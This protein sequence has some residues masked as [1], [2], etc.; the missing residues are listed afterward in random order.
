MGHICK[1]QDKDDQ[2]LATHT[3]T[4]SIFRDEPDV[5]LGSQVAV[6]SQHRFSERTLQIFLKEMRLA[7][8][9]DNHN[10]VSYYFNY[11]QLAAEQVEL[12]KLKE[13]L[14]LLPFPFTL[15]INKMF[16]N[17]QAY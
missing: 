6:A 10:E 4:N 17:S 3:F 12:Q 9:D 2:K 14:F 15:K 16:I 7:L 8:K 13:K 11:F 5:K 1:I